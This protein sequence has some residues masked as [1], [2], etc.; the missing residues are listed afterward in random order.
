M[1]DIGYQIQDSEQK[2]ISREQAKGQA[3]SKQ[4]NEG[5]IQH[6]NILGPKWD[7]KPELQ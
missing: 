2:S 5:N 6:R 4:H 7:Q 3:I 1:N